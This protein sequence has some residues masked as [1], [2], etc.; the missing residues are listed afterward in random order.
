MKMKI[1]KFSQPSCTPC[2]ILGNFLD[3][4]GIPHEEKD[5]SEMASHG[6]N[7]MGA[8]VLLL[9]EDDGTPIDFVI[10]F[11]PGNPSQVER[12]LAQYNS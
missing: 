8:P 6:I 5:V 11:N 7:V 12:I 3:T 1:I 10:G 4:R 9:A 2:I